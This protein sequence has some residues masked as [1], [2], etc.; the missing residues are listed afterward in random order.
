MTVLRRVKYGFGT[1]DH[2]ACDDL[3]S[4]HGD[5]VRATKIPTPS[6][7]AVQLKDSRLAAVGWLGPVETWKW[8]N[9]HFTR[10]QACN[11][12]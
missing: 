6:L 8:T 10:G 11:V 1:V 4:H 12:I 9:M 5:A 3:R 7:V 2:M